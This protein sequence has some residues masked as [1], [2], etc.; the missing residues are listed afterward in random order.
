MKALRG[1][2]AGDLTMLDAL[3]PAAEFLA[4]ANGSAAAAAA[5]VNEA[6]EQGAEQTRGMLPMK[7]RS[8][9]IGQRALGH[10]DPGAYA[11]TVSTKAIAGAL[12]RL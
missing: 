4:S 6:A 7:G 9:Y 10:V 11:V 3:L 1:A 12:K 2:T 8:S 5:G